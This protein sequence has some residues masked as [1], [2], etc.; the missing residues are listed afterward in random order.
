M[1]KTTLPERKYYLDNLRTFA[2][3]LLVPFH[4]PGSDSIFIKLFFPWWQGL[5]FVLAGITLFHSFSRRG[6]GELIKERTRKLLVPLLFGL[7]LIVPTE[8][9][10]FAFINTET[11]ITLIILYFCHTMGFMPCRSFGFFLFFV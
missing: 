4:T 1:Q 9:Y 10:F 6:L 2:I 5:M 7:L 3:L 8:K 11:P